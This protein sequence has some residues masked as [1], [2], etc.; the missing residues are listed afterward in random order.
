MDSRLR[1]NDSRLVKVLSVPKARLEGPGTVVRDG[2]SPF[3][4]L[5]S[6]TPSLYLDMMIAVLEKALQHRGGWPP[7]PVW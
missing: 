1:G 5:R 6:L 7:T 3:D 4:K 2:L